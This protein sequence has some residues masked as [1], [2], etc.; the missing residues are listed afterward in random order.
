MRADEGGGSPGVFSGIDPDALKGTIDSVRRDQDTLQSRAAY[1]RTRLAYYGIGDTE[2]G[3]VL[4]VAAWARD[5]L[6]MLK[7]RHHLAMRMENDPYPGFEG[8]VRIDEARVTRAANAVAARDAKRATELAKKNPQ[9]LSPQEFDELNA[10]LAANYDEYPFAEKLVGAL[11][12]KKTLRLWSDLSGLGH[13]DGYGQ[14]SDFQRADELDDMQKNLS[15]TIAAATNSDSPAMT[16]WKKDMVAIGDKPIRDFGPSPH[17]GSAGPE[18]FVVMS[19]LMRY[20]DYDD[21]FLEDY[22][23]ALIKEDR[24]VL[25]EAG[26]LYGTGWGTE[27]HVNHLGNDRGTDPL[28]GYMKALANSPD[29]ATAFFM[30]EQKGEDG[31]PESNFKYLFEE[32]K[33]PNDSMPGKE[34]VTGLNSM[35][36]ALEA[37]TTG[38]RPGEQATTE[39]T[40]HSQD[41]ADLFSALVKSVSEDQDRLRSHAFLSDSFA[42]ISAEYMPDIH[43]ALDSDKANGAKLFPL[44]GVAAQIQKYD[45]ARFLHAVARNKEGYDRLNVSQ[46]VY[47]AA[48]MEAYAKHPDAYPQN[49]KGTINELAYETGLFQGVIGAGRHFQADKDGMDAD[50]RDNAWKDQVGTWGGSLVGS[51]TAIATAPFTGPGGVVAG[52]LAGTASGEI[53]NGI[54]EGFGDNGDGLKQQV[55]KNVQNMGQVED[56]AILT[57]QESVKAA[58]GS[59]EEESRAGHAAGKG[60][61]D[62]DSL[63]SDSEAAA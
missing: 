26:Q 53:F 9:D 33:W 24:R 14:T 37:A 42:N 7:R 52:G 1:Y 20:G 47:A 63:V 38:H 11:G 44:P 3:D 61:R 55:Y 41:Q 19:N 28:T 29:A 2:L 51:A 35:G 39:D 48:L 46:H 22:G 57:T 13:P 31:K 50:A 32:R 62:A 8:V 59:E 30:A 6:P 56:S 43:R 40:K 45:A 34:S 10:L 27:E 21:K 25:E 17:S 4:K 54:L 60:F 12:A 23:T 18:G 58:T 15:L 49:T 5:E 16:K 36:H